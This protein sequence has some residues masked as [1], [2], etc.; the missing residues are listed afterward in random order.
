[1]SEEVSW[2]RLDNK[3]ASR[4]ALYTDGAIDDSDSDLERV[5]NWHIEKTP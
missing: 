3:R 5:K 4:L 2:E 1:M